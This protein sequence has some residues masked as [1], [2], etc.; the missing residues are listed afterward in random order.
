LIGGLLEIGEALVED[1]R[2]W[3]RQQSVRLWLPGKGMPR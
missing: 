1:L 3:H 2:R